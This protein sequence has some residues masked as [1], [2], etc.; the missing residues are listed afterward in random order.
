[1]IHALAQGAGQ[2]ARIDRMASGC[3]AAALA[4]QYWVLFEVEM[5]DELT[6]MNGELP[7]W[8]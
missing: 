2:P 7:I 8:L 6:P 4:G 1:M 5:F 3:P